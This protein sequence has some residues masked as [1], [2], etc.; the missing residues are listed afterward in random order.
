MIAQVQLDQGSECRL[1][2]PGGVMGVFDV[3]GGKVTFSALTTNLSDSTGV[4]SDALA[5]AFGECES[6][7]ITAEGYLCIFSKDFGNPIRDIKS[8]LMNAQRM[9]VA[10]INEL[11]D[12]APRVC[13]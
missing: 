4:V 12:S 10:V 5:R 11:D 13:G 6:V 9:F 3:S 2:I 8:V 7:T 1:D